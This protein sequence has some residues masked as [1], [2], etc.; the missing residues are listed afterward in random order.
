MDRKKRIQELTPYTTSPELEVLWYDTEVNPPK[1]DDFLVRRAKGEPYA[2]I[3]GHKGFWKGDFK[4]SPDV[5]DPRPDSEVLI[6]AVL[7][8]FPDKNA[9]LKIFDI[10]TGSGCLLASLLTEYRGATGVGVDVS[11]QALQIAKENLKDLPATLY[12]RDFYD[13]TWGHNLGRF[14]IILSNPPYI[15]TGDLVGLDKGTLFDPVLA[16]DGGPDGLNAYRALAHSVGTLLKAGGA[17]FLEIGQ[18]QEQDV[19]TL[20]Q[21]AGFSLQKIFPDYGGINRILFFQK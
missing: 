16:L 9:P 3:M 15:K 6:E 13:P 17:L 2:K 7:K 18:G 21:K 4:V 20:F 11:E 14:D 10:G 19:M 12:Q 1:W 5:L 8:T